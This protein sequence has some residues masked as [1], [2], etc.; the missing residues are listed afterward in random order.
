MGSVVHGSGAWP[1]VSGVS[2]RVWAPHAEKVSVIGS[3]NN[4]SPD[5]D[6][7]VAE[8]NGRWFR[9]VPSARVG[10][11]YKYLILRNGKSMYRVDPYARQVDHAGGNA[12]VSRSPSCFQIDD[13]R[14]PPWHELVLYEIH[15]GTFH[16]HDPGRPG[17]FSGVI[18]KL[19]YLREL[20]VNAIELMPVAEFPFDFSWGYN[21]VHLFAVT[22]TYGGPEALGTLITEAHRKGLA[23]IIDVVYNHVGPSDLDLWQFDGWDENARGGIY[24]YNDWRA[25]T[26]WGETRPDYGRGEVR[27][28]L[29]DNAMMWLE[30]YHV[31]GLRFDSTSF[32]RATNGEGSPT[33]A[34]GRSL[35]QWI[36]REMQ[37]R[38]PGRICIAEDVADREEV[39]R[40]VERDG[41]GFSA[42]WDCGFVHHLRDLISAVDDRHRSMNAL[43]EALTCAPN[44]DGLQRIVYSESHDSV[45][46]GYLRLPSQIDPGNPTSW[47]ARKRLSLASA[48]VLTAP[49]IPMLFQGQEFLT[50]GCFDDRTPL[51]W[52]RLTRLGGMVQLFRDLIGL[53]RNRRGLTRGLTS[54]NI[55]ILHID[56]GAKIIAYHRWWDGGPGDDVVVVANFSSQR[57]DDYHV[58]LPSRGAWHIRFNSDSRF[59]SDDFGD[60]PCGPFTT[61]DEPRDGRPC[62]ATLQ[63]SPYSVLILSQNPA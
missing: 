38:Y 22:S 9:H 28:F 8:E 34:D 58:G 3:F 60:F 15:V 45:A 7:L 29:Y 54:R 48:M 17:D 33:L 61:R 26:P 47:H 13:F 24:F 37:R 14:M 43:R 31:D 12:V 5:A 62:S 27:Q 56:D 50:E 63:I 1:E 32:V 16:R 42:Q 35:L 30:E 51:D 36:N 2:F 53:R 46:N 6:P 21:P 59:Y 10:D 39:T 18:E 19:D 40:S 57:W 44:G 20:G 41:L 23:V 49:A 4:W 11:P 55:N 52:N 25:Q